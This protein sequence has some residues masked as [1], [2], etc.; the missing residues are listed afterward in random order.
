MAT[1]LDLNLG[2]FARDDAVDEDAMLVG[3]GA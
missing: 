2:V 1:V 3:L